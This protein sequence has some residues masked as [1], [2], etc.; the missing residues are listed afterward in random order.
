MNENFDEKEK[1]NY[2]RIREE[3][4]HF[5]VSHWKIPHTL[6]NYGSFWKHAKEISAMFKE[7]KPLR[8]EL[9]E[10][11]WNMYSS[12][13]EEAKIRHNDEHQ[14]KSWKSEDIKKDIMREI[15][16]AE[17]QDLFGFDLP[18]VEEMKRLSQV[19]KDARRLLSEKK[20]MMLPGHR[21]ECHNFIQEVQRA[22]DAWWEDLKR[23]KYERT[24]ETRQNRLEKNRERLRKAT[25]A[26]E[27]CERSANDLRDKIS[28]AYSDEWRDKAVG[29]LSVLEDKIRDIEESI[30]RIE[31]WIK[32][33]E[34]D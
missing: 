12:I 13:C 2:T 5:S 32:E 18:N 7:L 16:S 30:E 34:N 11:L 21:Q 22:Q 24:E 28:T 27:S 19:L 6:R 4:E 29:W 1:S 33:D 17:V 3:I 26:L 31:G 8:K 9:R 25:N 10:E 20:E 15:H 23:Q 14:D